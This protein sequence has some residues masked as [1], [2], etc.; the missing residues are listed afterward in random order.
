MNLSAPDSELVRLGALPHELAVIRRSCA[1]GVE[2][3]V[4][5]TG[6]IHDRP[7]EPLVTVP[8]G[9]LG[10]TA[11]EPTH[12]P[13]RFP[14]IAP[15]ERF[16]PADFGAVETSTPAPAPP[17]EV[18]P[19]APPPAEIV[20]VIDTETTGLA[21]E[22]GRI[23]EI[24]C[25]RADLARSRIVDVW[26]SK[27]TPGQLIDPGVRVPGHIT[28]LTGIT[29]AMLEGK[30]KLADVWPSLVAFIG[31]APVVA[32]NAQFDRGMFEGELG[33]MGLLGPDWPR[34]PWFCS[35][36]IAKRV[37]PGLPTYS[38]S[39]RGGAQGLR[40][41]LG[42]GEAKAHRAHGDVLTTCALLRVLRERA[43]GPWARWCGAPLVWGVGK[44]KT[45]KSGGND[46]GPT[47]AGVA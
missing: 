15:A 3:A 37:V 2:I 41:L 30:P 33:R 47:L 21:H 29:S 5:S 28:A 11:D 22:D 42:L 1:L 35:Q 34:W 19:A 26:P 23:T 18:A 40:H 31:D 24:A 39:G 14:T 6:Y 9:F 32:H 44:G 36:A 45:K 17:V 27:R 7:G 12:Q 16:D 43:G 13:R 4:T 25:V 38:L 46:S 8:H 10:A 20:T